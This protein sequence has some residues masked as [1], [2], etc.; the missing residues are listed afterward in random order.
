M[1]QR[2]ILPLE[3]LEAMGG[4]FA[5]HPKIRQSARE[6]HMAVN[7]LLYARREHKDDR[8][9]RANLDPTYRALIN[10]CDK[11]RRSL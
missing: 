11:V 1:C 10:A 5:K 8:E 9:E 2:I 7:N 6:L 3:Q 4:R